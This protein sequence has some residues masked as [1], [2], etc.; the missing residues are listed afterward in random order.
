[1][2]PKEFNRNWFRCARCNRLFLQ[3]EGCLNGC[4][5]SHIRLT[6]HSDH[7]KPYKSIEKVNEDV[8]KELQYAYD[9]LT[10][11]NTVTKDEDLPPLPEPF[12]TYQ[13]TSDSSRMPV[14]A[15]LM[16]RPMIAVFNT[17]QVRQIQREAIEWERA[18]KVEMTGEEIDI[19]ANQHLKA[20]CQF[21]GGGDVWCEGEQPFARAI[22]ATYEAKR[23]QG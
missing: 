2:T 9:V 21:I 5:L 7:G 14:Y 20:H 22:I 11:G 10:K 8:R 23:R 15:P 13:F 6:P 17:E 16:N 3:A 18:R 1:M 19:L 4:Y 12:R